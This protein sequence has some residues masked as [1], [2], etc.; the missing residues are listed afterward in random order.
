M[1]VTLLK[2]V[3]ILACL[4]LGTP[5][6]SNATQSEIVLRGASSPSPVSGYGSTGI[7]VR[8]FHFNPVAVGSDLTYTN[9]TTNGDYITVN[10]DGVYAISYTGT[11]PFADTLG[12]SINQSA[13]SYLHQLAKDSLVC[14]Q[15]FPA[16]TIS[17]CAGTLSLSSG[18]VIRAHRDV[19][20]SQS[21]NCDTNEDEHLRVVRVD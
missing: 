5:K 6:I 11:S 15:A 20:G 2:T 21:C 18:D 1:R 13:T 16:S 8:V 4:M 9:D 14:Q 19:G 3:A 10:T 12:V 17:N 7:Y